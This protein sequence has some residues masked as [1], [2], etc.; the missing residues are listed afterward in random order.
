MKRALA[1]VVTVALVAYA[2][3]VAPEGGVGRPAAL[4]LGFALIAAALTGALFERIRLPRVS[5]YLQQENGL[6]TYEVRFPNG[7]QNVDRR[8]M[9]TP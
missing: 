5:G 1:L 4:A 7:K 8:G 3:R 9:L 2:V 6:V